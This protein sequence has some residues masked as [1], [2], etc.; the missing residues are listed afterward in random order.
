MA[1]DVAENVSGVKDVRNE[2][3]VQPTH[4]GYTGATTSGSAGAGNVGGATSG[5][6]TSST[7]KAK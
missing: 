7:A 3:R 5:T 6:S 4:A 1:E 2:L